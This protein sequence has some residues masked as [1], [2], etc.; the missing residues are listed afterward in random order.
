MKIIFEF[1]FYLFVVFILCLPLVLSNAATNQLKIPAFPGAQGFGSYTVGGRGGKVI[2]VTNLNNDGPGSLRAALTAK[3][4]RIVVFRISGT[5]QLSSPVFIDNPYITIAG[6]TAPG[7]GICIKGSQIIIRTHDVVL[8]FIRIRPGDGEIGTNPENRDALG[9]EGISIRSGDRVYNVVIDHCSFSWAIDGN[10]DLWRGPRDITIQNCI[11]SESL[12]NSTHPKGAHGTALLIGAGSRNI[13]VHCNL[14]AHN[15]ARNPLI[16][17]HTSVVFANNVIYNWGE[18]WGRDATKITDGQNHAEIQLPTLIDIINNFYKFGSDGGK[19]CLSLSDRMPVDTKIYLSGN[20]V[21]VYPQTAFYSCD[22]EKVKIITRDSAK[23]N[24]SLENKY[25]S[26]VQW[27]K[28]FPQFGAVTEAYDFVLRNAGAILPKRDDVDKRIIQDVI[29]GTGRI[30]DSQD[31]VGGWPEL[32]S[33]KPPEDTDHDGMPDEWELNH[34][35]NPHNP[36]DRNADWDDDGYTNIE[37]YLNEIVS[38]QINNG[39]SLF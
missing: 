33:K 10:I 30:I 26:L 36:E 11:I 38:G 17:S 6:Q 22:W 25:K 3:G 35:L 39:Q 14:F 37:E 12:R 18:T 9:I 4:R 16:K 21:A 29:N 27:N 8:R 1:R 15:M 7:D 19:I 32:K 2:E 34:G 28:V 13:S 20:M 23:K 31:E 24:K 5:I